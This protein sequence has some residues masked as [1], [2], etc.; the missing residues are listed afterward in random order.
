[1][2]R[3]LAR[4]GPAPPKSLGEVET[5]VFYFINAC[6]TRPQF[7]AKQLQKHLKHYQGT[8]CTKKNKNLMTNEG[9]D[10]VQEA[11]NELKAKKPIEALEWN[12]M[13]AKASTDHVKDTGPKGITGH[14]G[15]DKS[16]AE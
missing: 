13:L 12:D 5:Q 10:A 16:S 4:S 7:A 15:S 3:K 11:I 1:M 9:A 8:K 2:Y 14:T 6:R